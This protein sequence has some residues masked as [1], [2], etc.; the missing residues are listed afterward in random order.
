MSLIKGRTKIELFDAKSGKRQKVVESS[1]LVTNALNH[2]INFDVMGNQA[3]DAYVFP[4]AAKALGGIMLFDG[5]ITE[6]VNNIYFPTSVHLVGHADRAVGTTPLRGSFNSLESGVTEDGY[7]SVWDFGTS[8]ANGNIKSICL[9]NQTA[10]TQV[11]APS[12]FYRVNDWEYNGAPTSDSN[13]CPIRFNND[14]CYMIK[15]GLN[16]TMRLSRIRVPASGRKVYDFHR[17]YSNF[18]EIASWNTECFSW[19][20]SGTVVKRYANDVRCYI[21]GGDGYIYAFMNAENDDGNSSGDG[22]FSYFTIKY[23]DNSFEKSEWQKVTVSGASLTSLYETSLFMLS[24]GYLYIRSYNSKGVYRINMANTSDVRYVQCVD[25]NSSDYVRTFYGMPLLNGGGVWIQIHHY[26]ETSNYFI[27]GLVY[28]D[29]T[30]LIDQRGVPDT[31]YIGE[32]LHCYPQNL[33]S[34]QNQ[35]VGQAIYPIIQNAYL[36][37]INNLPSVVEKNATQTMKITYTLTNT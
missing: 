21:D 17:R 8:Q 26:T 30:V 27:A 24:N 19:E 22:A 6:N 3:L 35:N 34:F 20:R 1:N 37:T 36:G 4:I 28:E 18:E 32:F 13:W 16:N 33:I 10:G 7:R 12:S 31:H 5:D 11:L 29:L 15:S 9:T 14:Y 2:L 23:S 25:N